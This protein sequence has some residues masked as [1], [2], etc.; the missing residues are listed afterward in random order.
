MGTGLGQRCSLQCMVR[1]GRC[2]QPG[3]HRHLLGSGQRGATLDYRRAGPA[4]LY[5]CLVARYCRVYLLL[6]LYLWTI[7]TLLRGQCNRGIRKLGLSFTLCQQRQLGVRTPRHAWGQNQLRPQQFRLGSGGDWRQCYQ[8]L[9]PWFPFFLRVSISGVVMA[10]PSFAELAFVSTPGVPF[11]AFLAPDSLD[12]SR[13]VSW[14]SL[15]GSNFVTPVGSNL[16]PFLASTRDMGYSV[17][18]TSPFVSGVSLFVLSFSS[19]GALGLTILYTG[20]SVSSGISPSTTPGGVVC[21]SLRLPAVLPSAT[22]LT[23]GAL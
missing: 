1:W 8:I 2:R 10:N 18:E 5:V 4:S 15:T 12:F 11:S 17:A 6:F 9:G 23:S 13:W 16:F 22:A 3:F 21:P 7:G 14:C 19:R 20:V